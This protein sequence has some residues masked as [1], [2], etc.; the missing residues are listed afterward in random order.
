MMSLLVN[1]PHPSPLPSEGEGTGL[2]P[3][4]SRLIG[5][6]HPPCLLIYQG[7]RGGGGAWASPR[8]LAEPRNDSVK[9]LA[10]ESGQPRGIGI[11]GP[12]YPA[13]P[14]DSASASADLRQGERPPRSLAGPRDDMLFAGWRE[15]ELAEANALLFEA[16][17]PFFVGVPDDDVIQDVYAEEFAGFH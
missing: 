15:K 6:A 17:E 16:D 14:F 8:F 1:H 12:P 11:K 3:T 2:L 13:R 4:P 10:W 5:L 9:G 7:G